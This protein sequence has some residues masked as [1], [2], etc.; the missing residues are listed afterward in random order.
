MAK[1]IEGHRY[2]QYRKR[3]LAKSNI[4]HLCG[5]E[6]DMSLDY[7]HPMSATIDHLQ[8]RSKG[9]DV[10]GD[11]LPAHRSCNSRRGNRPLTPK[12]YASR[13]W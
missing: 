13:D 4:C 9:G 2:R 8:A 12:R 7:R 1:G 10:F 3:V 6:I 11:A 5:R